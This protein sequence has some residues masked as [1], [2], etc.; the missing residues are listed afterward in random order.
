MSEKQNIS[1]I[2]CQVTMSNKGDSI[3]LKIEKLKTA[4]EIQVIW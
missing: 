3:T 2:E 1:N 4:R